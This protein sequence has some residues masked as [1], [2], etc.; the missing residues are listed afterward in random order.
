MARDKNDNIES[1]VRA[2]EVIVARIGHE[3]ENAYLNT[4]RNNF[5]RNGRSIDHSIL[6]SSEGRTRVVNDM[7]SYLESRIVDYLGFDLES[8]EQKKIAFKDVLGVSRTEFKIYFAQN[9]N[10]LSKG[11]IRKV[12]SDYKNKALA[13][14]TQKALIGKGIAINKRTGKPFKINDVEELDDE[15][16]TVINAGLSPE[17]FVEL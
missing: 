1:Y 3:W 6:K 12:W 9:K 13:I 2:V 15:E 8:D 17:E 16:A 14:I 11:I 7:I 4:E 10:A 5:V